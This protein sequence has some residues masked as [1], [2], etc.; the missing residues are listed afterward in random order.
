MRRQLNTREESGSLTVELMEYEVPGETA[1]AT[2]RRLF[3]R[4]HD[5]LD[6]TLHIRDATGRRHHD[7]CSDSM[8]TLSRSDR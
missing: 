6:R 1:V 4:R 5:P 7:G 8:C 3:R 2:E